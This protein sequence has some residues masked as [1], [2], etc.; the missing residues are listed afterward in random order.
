MHSVDHVTIVGPSDG[1]L[2]IELPRQDLRHRA[3]LAGRTD[4][5]GARV[6]AALRCANGPLRARVLA[7]TLDL[8]SSEVTAALRRLQELGAATSRD[9]RWTAVIDD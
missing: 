1:G 9:R 6:R 5:T 7:H 8:P 4:R 2:G 3:E